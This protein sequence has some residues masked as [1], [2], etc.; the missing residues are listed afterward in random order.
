MQWET[1]YC[2]N[3]ISVDAASQIS[4]SLNDKVTLEGGVVAHVIPALR[5]LRQED[6]EFEASLGY[7][8]TLSLPSYSQ[9]VRNCFL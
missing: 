6:G 3:D 8:E 4:A 7:I 2:P 9:K 1:V 5:S